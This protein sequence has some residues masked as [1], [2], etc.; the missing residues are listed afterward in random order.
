ML[1]F[2]VQLMM[3]IYVNTPFP[4]HH[5]LGQASSLLDLIFS[6]EPNMVFNVK[7]LFPLGLSDHDILLWK[8]ICYSDQVSP[9]YKCPFYNYYK[10][11]YISM[12]NYLSNFDWEPVLVIII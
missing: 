1:N 8:F 2:S 11:N 4:T 12:N 10:G 7:H 6:S 9:N 5:R 3:P